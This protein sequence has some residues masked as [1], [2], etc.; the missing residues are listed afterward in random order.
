MGPFLPEVFSFPFYGKDVSD[1]FAE[2]ESTKLIEEAF[3]KYLPPQDV[4]AIFIEI[5]QGD[6]GIIPAHPIF[7]KKLYTLYKSLRNL[8]FETK[9]LF[10][11]T[12]K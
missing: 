1:E 9:K 7:I 6:A 2:K 12:K 8:S 5:V 10:F 3:E 11:S 4:S